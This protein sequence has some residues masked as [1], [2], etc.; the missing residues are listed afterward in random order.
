MENRKLIGFAMITL[1]LILLFLIVYFIFFHN[2]YGPAEEV[3]VQL[4]EKKVLTEIPHK[5]EIK[6]EKKPVN[7]EAKPKKKI[8]TTNAVVRQLARLFAERF[9]SYSNQAGYGNIEELKVF[10]SK[11]MSV[12]ADRYIKEEIAKHPQVDI[13]YGITTRAVTIEEK[14]FNTENGQAKYVVSTQRFEAT[15]SMDNKTSRQQDIVITLIK[16]DDAWKVDSA[17][18]QAE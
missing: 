15:G 9:G 16:E 13:Y 3:N 11:R 6:E 8:D 18:W 14:E 17:I 7:D 12:W 10:M 4:E 5:E 1:G 2:F